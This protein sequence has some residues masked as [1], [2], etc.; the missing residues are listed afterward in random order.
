MLWRK[1]KRHDH[2]IEERRIPEPVLMRQAIYD[3]LLEPAEEIAV[4]LG[5]PPISEE[6][7]EMEEEA[8]QERLD[9]FSSLMPFIDAHS[10]LIARIASS[11]W[12]NTEENKEALADMG[13]EDVNQLTE[14]LKVVSLSAVLSCM[15]ALFNLDLLETKVVSHFDQ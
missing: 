3:S 13:I 6:V 4:S 10:G 7:R 2:L 14:M 15:S 1:K 5:L 12:A 11:A 9:K 8:S